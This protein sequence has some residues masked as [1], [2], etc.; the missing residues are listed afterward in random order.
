[1][2]GEFGVERGRG[3]RREGRNRKEKPPK[4]GGEE[5]LGDVRT[6][7]R[8]GLKEMTYWTKHRDQERSFPLSILS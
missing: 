6:E 8:K 5:S 2:K 3:G 4:A 1:M 7:E